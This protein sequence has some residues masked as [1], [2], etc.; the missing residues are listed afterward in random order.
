[1]QSTEMANGYLTLTRGSST[2]EACAHV[3]RICGWRCVVEDGGVWRM[4]VVCVGNRRS[5][6]QACFHAARLSVKMDNLTL[7]R[8]SS[9]YEAC[10]H[11]P[12]MC[13]PRLPI[14]MVLV[15]KILEHEDKQRHQ[16]KAQS[17]QACC[18]RGRTS[19][20]AYSRHPAT[21]LKSRP[22]KYK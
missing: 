21:L 16:Y 20:D 14:P 15:P 5:H 8:M 11:V 1:M 6:C 12:P 4:V 10:A 3:P 22:C 18:C 9:T 19:T 17:S 7:A 13:I 2:Y